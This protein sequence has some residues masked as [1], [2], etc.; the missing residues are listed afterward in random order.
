M[1]TE[2]E[3]FI[4]LVD[5]DLIKKSDAIIL[6]E[7]D[8]LNRYLE[9]VRLYKEKYSKLIVFSGGAIDYQYG[10]YPFADIKPLLLKEGVTEE[11][12]L[13]EKDSM[14]TKQQ[15]EEVAKLCIQKRLNSL[16]LVASSYHQ[17]RAYLTFLKTFS[18]MGLNIPIY[19]SPE[20]RLKWFSDNAWGCRIECLIEEFE[21]IE[22]YQEKGD[23]STYKKA[24]EYQRWKEQ[25]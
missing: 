3:I 12:I 4:S 16:I 8:G 6:L 23:L 13:Y 2:R 15:S 17:Y 25:Q 9:A 24:I 20:R 18:D 19:N 14:Q 5:N 21:K 10:S 1:L 11:D 7:G 22:K